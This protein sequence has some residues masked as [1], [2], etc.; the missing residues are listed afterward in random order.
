MSSVV[1]KW[2]AILF[3]L[4]VLG[5]AA[6]GIRSAIHSPLFLVQV[7]EVAELTDG[8]PLDARTITDLAR[9]P[10][11]KVNLFELDLA[12]VEKRILAN[13][14]IR[15]VRLTKRFP[16]TLAVA[17]TFREPH[18][19]FQTSRGDL[20]YV[21]SDGQVFGR[22]NLL[23]QADLP[24]LTGFSPKGRR[25][26]AQS[27]QESRQRIADAL[28]LIDGWER[29][30]V[31][32]VCRI[33]SLSWDAERGYHAIVYYPLAQSG[34]RA[35]AA[36]DFGRAIDLSPENQFRRLYSVFRYLNGHSIAATEI[37]ADSG[38]KIVVRTS[39]GS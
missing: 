37:W 20:A 7:V 39:H 4:T 17:V 23:T 13:P 22:V 10:L 1:Q 6:Y 36:V 11:G 3:L 2:S 8:A 32:S 18:A 30:P 19:L 21:D 28:R 24:I 5:G 33:S 25:P 12:D 34:T 15:E 16:Q 31:D 35:R 14:W 27:V 26:S 29:S 9:V 38:K